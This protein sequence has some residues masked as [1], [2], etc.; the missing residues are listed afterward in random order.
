MKKTLLIFAAIFMLSVIITGVYFAFF[1]PKLTAQNTI[2][3][4]T[5]TGQTINVN[6]FSKDIKGTTQTSQIMADTNQYNIVYFNADKSF[7]VT[8][9]L[10]P[11]KD[12]RLAAEQFL[13]N[14]LNIDQQ[15]ACQLKISVKT[16]Y[17]VSP[18]YAGNELGLSF[19]P[20]TVLLP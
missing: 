4:P 10:M 14:E 3:V 1:A 17:S 5:T 2:Q 16:I 18:D 12:S 9:N 8:L 15:A 6:N 13:L 19:C 11:L 7:L 20:N